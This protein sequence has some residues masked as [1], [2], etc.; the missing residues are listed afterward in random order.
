M[1]PLLQ[2]DATKNMHHWIQKNK[3]SITKLKTKQRTTA[4]SLEPQVARAEETLEMVATL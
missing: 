2:P 4:F 3:N 1:G